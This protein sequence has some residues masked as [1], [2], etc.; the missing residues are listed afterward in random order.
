MFPAVIALSDLPVKT[1]LG[2]LL[3]LYVYISPFSPPLVFS[4]A[5]IPPVSYGFF[6]KLEE[7][8]EKPAL[9]V[10]QFPRLIFLRLDMS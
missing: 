2:R 10:R 1:A 8:V 7:F 9:L 6:Y 3:R 4:I 5:S